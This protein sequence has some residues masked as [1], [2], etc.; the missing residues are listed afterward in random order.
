MK[1]DNNEKVDRPR[2]WPDAPPQRISELVEGEKLFDSSG[3]SLVKITKLCLDETD[4]TTM[5][6]KEQF[7][8]LPIK[9]TGVSEY[10]DQL[11][12]K[13]PRPPVIKRLIKKNTK[14]GKELG[15]SHDKMLQIFDSTDEDYI[16]ALEK[17]NQDFN[18]KV[19]IFAL[20][21]KWTKKDGS[22]ATTIEDKKQV[23]KTNDITWAHIA[24]IFTDVKNLTRTSEDQED[25][26]SDD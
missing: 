25:F 21:L 3:F 5:K 22:E 2:E 9:S 11:S 8:E 24:Q 15:L 7:I 10:I 6:A 16:D 18:W 4:G 19:A 17:H 13:A 14:E 23:L 20:D 1:D 12:G 26:L